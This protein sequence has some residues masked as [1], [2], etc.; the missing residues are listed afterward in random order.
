MARKKSMHDIR[1]QSIRLMQED[2]RNARFARMA[3]ENYISRA[4]K[5]GNI[6]FHYQQNTARANKT[7]PSK[8][9]D[10]GR[11]KKVS[12]TRSQRMGLSNG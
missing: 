4:E 12:G 6:A 9:F 5:I 8:V 10:R 7:T 3:G 11:E 1:M 2:E